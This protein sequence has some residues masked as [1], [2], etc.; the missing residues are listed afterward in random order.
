MFD[1]N[2]SWQV[3]FGAILSLFIALMFFIPSGT[4]FVEAADTII[5]DDDGTG[6]YTSIQAAINNA[7]V[8]D[9]IV[10]KDGTYAEQLTVNVPSINIV[11]ASGETPVIYVSS[12]PV[13]I[14]VTAPDVLI[15]GFEIFGNGSLTFGPYPTI[16]ASAGS[17]G[18][19]V[20]NN[21]FK[22]FTGEVGQMALLIV[23]DVVNVMFNGNIVTNYEHSVFHAAWVTG[24]VLYFGSIQDVIDFA[25]I[26]ATVMVAPGTYNQQITVNKSITLSGTTGETIIDLGSVSTYA[27]KLELGCD[28]A[29]IEGFEIINSYG[30]YV[31]SNAGGES[32]VTIQ[33]NHIHDLFVSS[34]LTGGFFVNASCWPPLE[35]WRIQDNTLENITGSLSSGLR[36]ENMKD[37]IIS[38]NTI[39]NM[40]YSGILLINVDGAIVSSNMIGSIAR[41]GI[42]VD[43]YCTRDI[44]IIDNTIMQANT[45][46]YSGYG[47]IRFYGQHTPDPHSD[48]PAEITVIG[49]TCNGSYNGLAVRDGE[50]ISGRNI[51]ANSNSFINNSNMGVYHGGNGTLDATNNWWGNITGPYHPI[52]NPV[53][54]GD[55]VSDNVTFWPWYEFDGYSVKP[56]VEYEVGHPNSENGQFV[57]SYTPIKIT[58]YDDESGMKSLTY[59]IWNATHL[60]SGWYNYTDE[61]SLPGGDGKHRVEYNATDMAG[62][63]KTG[64][65]THYVDDEAPWIEVQ[66]PNGGEYVRGDLTILWDAA[67][68]MPDQKQI[69]RSDYYSFYPFSEDYPGHIQSFV[70]QHETLN[71]VDL[72]LHGDESEVNVIIFSSITPVPIPVGTTSKH[73]QDVGNEVYP[74]WI[75]FPFNSEISLEIGETYYIGVTQ[76]ILEGSGINWHYYNSTNESDPYPPGH[77]WIKKVDTLESHPELDWTFRTNYWNEFV[78]ATIQFSNAFPPIWSTIAQGEE[79]D[80]EFVWDTTPYPDGEAYLIRVIVEDFMSNSASDESDGPFT[81]DNTG[82]SVFNIEIIDTTLEST[83]YTKDG[84][85]LEISATVL[86]EISNVTAD[87]SGFGKGSFVEPNSLYQDTATWIVYNVNCAPADGEIT[88]TITVTDPNDDVA[89]NSGSIIADNTPPTLKI[90]RPLP[91]IFVMDGQ[92]LLPYPYPVIIG[93]ITIKVDANDMGAGVEK[94]EIYLDN[95]L[96]EIRNEVP[97]EWVWD[98]AS[99]GFFKLKAIAYDNVGFNATTL[100]NDIFILNF[101]ILD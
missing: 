68:Q 28:G 100:L 91:G 40:G 31:D 90:T 76:Q 30:I 32:N 66:D 94:V 18:L 97:Y 82:P 81:V 56:T 15:Q 86:G 48:P 75:T 9:N 98:E 11:A 43:S 87:L 6:D 13:G 4:I 71:A 77:S 29:T 95:K 58:A 41:A 39:S 89:Q 1:K 57:K 2:I 53:G 45:G 8:G 84:D 35:N 22:V 33:N 52:D 14:D 67:D 42:Q 70:P 69:K 38:G 93:Q 65:Q 62:T 59:R 37:V 44:S 64:I 72:L 36:P 61:F 3:R 46:S 63:K 73:L 17:D 79:N 21:D 99:I 10:V 26:G 80:G 88:V 55:N 83:E 16:R 27:I 25:Y 74:E 101:D 51:S 78:S 19:I 54:T 47:G 34:D 96:R 49:N 24:T 60:W 20:D 12:Y 7:G 23:N 92:R 50:N 5:V 85:R